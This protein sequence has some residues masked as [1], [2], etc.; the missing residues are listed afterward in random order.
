MTQGLRSELYLSLQCVRDA[1]VLHALFED[2]PSKDLLLLMDNV[3]SQFYLFHSVE[4]WW[5]NGLQCV[6]S[7]Y[8]QHLGQIDLDVHE[9]VLE[10]SILDGVQHL[11]NR[12]L[13]VASHPSIL[14]LIDLIEQDYRVLHMSAGD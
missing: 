8:E 3:S 1:I 4:Q 13:Q 7:T 12:V 6:G 11:H 5:E 2:V 9:I 14:N 10:P